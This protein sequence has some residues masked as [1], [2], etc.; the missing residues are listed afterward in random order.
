M[1]QSPS[2]SMHGIRDNH[3]RGNVAEFLRHR[4]SNG[5][6]LSVVSA[7]FAIHAYDALKENLDSIDRLRFLFGEPRFIGS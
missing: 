1:T 3:V 5:S 4:I 6:A 7:Y 2:I